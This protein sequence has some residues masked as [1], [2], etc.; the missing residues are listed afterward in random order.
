MAWNERAEN[1]LR[2]S[3]KSVR[4][5]VDGIPGLVAIMTPEGE[6]EFVNNQALEYFG[7]TLEELKSWATSDAVHPDGTNKLGR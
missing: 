4:R 1:V 5:I 6:V 2:E 3:E 7:R